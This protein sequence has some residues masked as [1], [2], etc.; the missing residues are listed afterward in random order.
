[1]ERGAARDVL[2]CAGLKVTDLRS[3][4]DK[5]DPPDCEAIIGGQRCGI[6]VTELI[7]QKA[8]ERSLKRLDARPN[9]EVTPKPGAEA[10]FRGGV[11]FEWTAE[12]FRADLQQRISRKDDASRVKGGPYDRYI[13]VIVTDEFTLDRHRVERFLEGTTF[14]TRFIDEVYLGL[15]YH[16]GPDLGGGSCP[17][18]QLNLRQG[19]AA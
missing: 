3:R 12:S 8:L 14:N 13:L 18:F 19:G 17:V 5:Q 11:Y 2:T 6:E 4:P 7:H 15:S 1:M 9:G 16:P 10:Y